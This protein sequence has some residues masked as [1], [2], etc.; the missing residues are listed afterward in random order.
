[1][2][3]GSLQMMLLT[4]FAH[5]GGIDAIVKTASNFSAAFDELDP[6]ATTAKLEQ[7]HV[8]SG[9]KVALGLLQ[10][11]VSTRVVFDSPQTA[12]LT[13]RDKPTSSE[14]YFDPHQFLVRLRLAILPFVRNIWQ[15]SWLLNAPVA[16]ARSVIH[17]ILSIMD[18]EPEIKPAV[19]AAPVH[20]STS[21]AAPGVPVPRPPPPPER[22]QQLVDMG[23]SAHAAT[24]ALRRCHNNT[25]FAAEFLLTHP[26]AFAAPPPPPPAAAPAAEPAAEASGAVP[27]AAAA[28]GDAAGV[29][30][31]QPAAEAA[32]Q[33]G[34]DVDM[35]DDSPEA[36]AAKEKEQELERARE[37]EREACW[38]D[39][40]PQLNEARKALTG[41]LCKRALELADRYESLV[42]DIKP[43]F[44]NSTGAIESI[45]KE[46]AALISEAFATKVSQVNVRLRLLSLILHDGPPSLVAEKDLAAQ[47][48]DLVLKL[49]PAAEDVKTSRPVWLPSQLHVAEALLILTESL[50][51]VDYLPA[52]VATDFPASVE[53]FQGPAF[54]EAR[55]ALFEQCL[56][57]LPIAELAREEFASAL[58][59]LVILTR[60]YPLA[61]DFARRGGVG[62]M[63]G[64]Y[65][66]AE[67]A[68]S[69][70]QAF[71]AIILRHIVESP[72]T[73]R[74][75][76]R[77]DVRQWF[78]S[79]R[80]KVVDVNHFIKNNRP[81]ALRNP[82]IFREVV[83]AECVVL[84]T[85]NAGVYHIM[86]KTVAPTATES[87]AAATAASETSVPPQTDAPKPDA[88]AVA[89]AE[90][91]QSMQVDGEN[92]QPPDFEVIESV[93][94]HL[95]SELMAVGKQATHAALHLEP[96]P[97]AAGTSPVA[98]STVA[99]AAVS[100]PAAAAAATP[101]PTDTVTPAAATA[102]PTATASKPQDSSDYV[103]A[104]LLMQNLTELL[105]SYM[106]C[107]AACVSFFFLP[108]MHLAHGS[109]G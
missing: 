41:D 74:E 79:P 93:V 21:Q 81:C 85:Y 80:T 66:A 7:V 89:A 54:N 16:V 28:E 102:A 8:F 36:L 47:V 1:M 77:R 108:S 32:A 17:T 86:L 59:L 90:A 107:K 37:K 61:L 68:H 57:L 40:R 14:D 46:T 10:S 52:D 56:A 3:Q 43:A 70:C 101:Q 12:Q 2:A 18:S 92:I 94:H 104:C 64:H 49:V 22:I 31:V 9:L 6:T 95:L 78:S 63:L 29:P 34:A 99:P 19:T 13:S 71:I 67:Q 39:H 26:G 51:Q 58:R 96:T 97:A 87:A 69:G 98:Q 35:A 25:S 109:I 33:P 38:E 75:I 53:L 11:L 27:A 23:F 103:Y 105:G 15:S 88:P 42:Y 100:T 44:V 5:R 60:D 24:E 55:S 65:K 72:D 30:A 106:S 20:I 83:A 45:T 76:M 82:R 48:M 91:A 84:E 4:A 62:L 50:N 73:L